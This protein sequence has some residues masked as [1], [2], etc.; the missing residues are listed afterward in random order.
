VQDL[1]WIEV[2]SPGGRMLS[3]HDG[4][5]TSSALTSAALAGT[6]GSGG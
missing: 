4:W 3:K 6:Q 2:T 1:P 5:L